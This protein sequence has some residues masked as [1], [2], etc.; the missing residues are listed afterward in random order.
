MT[1]SNF[2][3]KANQ[4]IKKRDINNDKKLQEGWEETGELSSTRYLQN[5][6]RKRDASV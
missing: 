6:K 5:F 2:Y 4:G 1:A 3:L